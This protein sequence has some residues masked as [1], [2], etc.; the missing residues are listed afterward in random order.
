MK[1][2]FYIVAAAGY[3]IMTYRLATGTLDDVGL[4]MACGSLAILGL[5]MLAK[6]VTV[7]TE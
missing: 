7:N 5:M 6:A 4:F 3:G 1:T 2:L